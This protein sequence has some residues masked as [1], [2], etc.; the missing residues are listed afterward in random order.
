MRSNLMHFSPLFLFFFSRFSFFLLA[1]SLLHF[2]LLIST[3]RSFPRSGFKN[4]CPPPPPRRRKR[5]GT[6]ILLLLLP[7][8]LLLLLLGLPLPALPGRSIFAISCC[9]DDEEEEELPS[10]VLCSSKHK[11]TME[12]RPCAQLKGNEVRDTSVRSRLQ[13]RRL[14][15]VWNMMAPRQALLLRMSWMQGGRT[16]R[17]GGREG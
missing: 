11:G 14:S 8:L 6:P 5:N 17:R 13:V 1:L 10:T 9:N 7:L 3:T 15:L 4:D 2:Y 16:W 12:G